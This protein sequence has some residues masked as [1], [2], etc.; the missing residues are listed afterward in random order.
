M[1]N[2]PVTQP[3]FGIYK[4]S[5]DYLRFISKT[6]PAVMDPDVTNIYCGPVYQMDTNRGFADYFVPIDVAF[7]NEHTGFVTSFLNGVFAGMM[8]FKRMIPCLPS[9]YELDTSNTKLTRF[10]NTNKQ[11]IKNCAE[12]VIAVHMR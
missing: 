3:E 8:D 12:T 4:I 2:T 11:F 1:N 6:N 9:E 5:E 10:C 7:Y